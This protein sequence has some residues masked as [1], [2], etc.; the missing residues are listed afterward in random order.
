MEVTYTRE[1]QEKVKGK[2]VTV[3]TKTKGIN[4]LVYK[5]ITDN[6]TL[7]WFRGLGGTEVTTKEFTSVGYKI[8]KLVSTCPSKTIRTVRTFNFD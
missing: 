4:F 1:D 2:W 6:K 8:V 5:Q 7:K 3:E